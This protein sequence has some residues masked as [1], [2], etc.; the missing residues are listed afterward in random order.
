M[1]FKCSICQ[2]GYSTTVALTTH[3]LYHRPRQSTPQL[4]P[5]I[6][7]EPE[8][9]VEIFVEIIAEESSEKLAVETTSEPV[10][11]E[12]EPATIPPQSEPEIQLEIMKSVEAPPLPSAEKK[13]PEE[14]P[15]EESSSNI[16]EV[17][18]KTISTPKRCRQAA[19]VKKRKAI[20][21]LQRK[22][23]INCDTHKEKCDECKFTCQYTS[24][25]DRHKGYIPKGKKNS[26][27]IYVAVSFWRKTN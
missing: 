13:V 20:R 2:R 15:S 22:R 8:Q 23:Q 7:V 5:E 4:E 3:M 26:D 25:L 6:S 17:S 12:S 11:M 21:S 27:V 19:A 1:P 24:Q 16:E 9:F 14:E 18:V 10:P